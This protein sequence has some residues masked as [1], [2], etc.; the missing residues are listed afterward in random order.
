MAQSKSKRSTATV[1]KK[2]AR[3][4]R[5]SRNEGKPI[6]FRDFFRM[7]ESYTSLLLGVVVVIIATVLL[8]V[9]FK[10]QHFSRVTKPSQQISYDKIE[11]NTNEY[12]TPSAKQIGFVSPTITTIL[13]PTSTPAI[14]NTPVPEKKQT[15]KVGTYIV[16]AG[17]DLWHIAQ[18]H[19]ND[20]YKWT[21]IAKANKLA[22]P[23]YIHVGDTL[24]LPE[25][26]TQSQTALL[27]Q[28]NTPELKGTS[29][30]GSNYTVMKGDD[31]WDIAVRAYGDGYRWV[32][33]AKANN[34]ARPNL[35]FS[36]NVL[37]IP[38]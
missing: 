16:K 12:S 32:D 20:G 3:V 21:E 9:F 26:A 18:S 27:S 35:I 4:K 1:S 25:V 2:T 19:Y 14:T 10:N 8:I 23:G 22:A 28:Q 6:A 24:T 36:G 11:P 5:S 7:T 38:R 15:I 30:S 34:L 33:I 13:T 29:I 31:L 37:T 17:D